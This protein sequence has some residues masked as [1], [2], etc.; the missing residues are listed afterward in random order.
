MITSFEKKIKSSA[1]PVLNAATIDTLQVNVGKLC[2]QI[3]KHCHVDA[4]PKRTEVMT[5]ET[6]EQIIQVLKANPS[7]RTLDITGGAPEM[8]PE[9]EFLADEAFKLGRHVIDRC[10]LTIFYESGKSHLPEFLKARHI[11]VVASLPCYL[12]ENVDSQRGKGVYQKSVDALLWLNT[13]GYGQAGSGFILNLVYNPVGAY[14]PPA[15]DELEADY[16]RELQQRFGIVFNRLLT[17][18]NMPISRFKSWLD[19]S[20]NLEQYMAKLEAAFNPATV[21]NL[22]CRSLVS[23]SWE[24]YLYDCDFNQMLDMRVNH[25]LPHHIKDFDV[26]VLSKRRIATGN[27]CYGC[28][29]GAGSSCGGVV[30]PNV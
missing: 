21:P 16:K 10:N 2:N 12:E 17:I 4:G 25:G 1:V 22:M 7:L 5:H 11:E 20:G 3:C 29:A 8:C 19:V 18:T 14:L 9:F 24:G 28:T 27:H 13:L 26:H 30:V 6:A 15:Q 23:V